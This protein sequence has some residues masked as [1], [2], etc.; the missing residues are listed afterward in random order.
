M[1][2]KRF[3]LWCRAGLFDRIWQAGLEKD[4]ELKGIDW[5]W[6]SADGCQVKVPLAQES[7]GPHPTDRGEKWEQTKCTDGG[8]W[9]PVVARRHRSES[10]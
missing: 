8:Q 1:L 6:Q 3:Q 10:A 2:H 7:V 5:E 9:C 4:E